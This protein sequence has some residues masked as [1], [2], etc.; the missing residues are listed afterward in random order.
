VTL[1]D[2]FPGTEA[3]RLLAPRFFCNPTAKTVGTVTTPI[4]PGEAHLACYKLTP[5]SQPLDDFV[6]ISNQ[7]DT[8][9][10]KIEPSQFVCAPSEK[11]LCDGGPCP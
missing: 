8:D 4:V 1:D 6:D 11:L 5:S 10:L 3:A 2:Q 9:T 7:F